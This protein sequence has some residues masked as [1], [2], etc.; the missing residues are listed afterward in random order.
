MRIIS[1]AIPIVGHVVLT[2]METCVGLLQR[3]D[4]DAADLQR[5]ALWTLGDD[6]PLKVEV[7]LI[8]PIASTNTN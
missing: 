7:S 8:R 3:H 2:S 6:V 1:L 4:L 5:E